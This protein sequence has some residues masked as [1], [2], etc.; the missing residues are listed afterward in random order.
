MLDDEVEVEVELE[1]AELEVLEGLDEVALEVLEGLDEAELEVVVCNVVLGEVDTL[2]EAELEV[3]EEVD[4]DVNWELALLVVDEVVDDDMLI[5][6]EQ[7]ELTAVGL[8][9]QFSRYVGMAA[10]FVL[11]VV[12]YVAQKVDAILEK[13]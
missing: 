12:V 11:A 2:E 3:V 6:H 8:M 10:E 7:A 13:R 5:R 9:K 1:E 4:S